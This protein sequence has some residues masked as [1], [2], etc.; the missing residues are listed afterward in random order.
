MSDIV[1]TG[2]SGGVGRAL[3]NL[4][5]NEN[6][7][8]YALLRNKD[9]LQNLN[10][11]KLTCIEYDARDCK[12]LDKAF[13]KI[14]NIDVLVNN[15]AIFQSKG[16]LEYKADEIDEIIDTNLKGSIFSTINAL[17]VMKKGRII[18]ISSVSGL[19]GI[20]N[21]TIYSS[22]KHGL[23][24]FSESLAQEIID[25]GIL[26]TDICPGGINTPLW[27]KDNPY[28]GD[29]SELILPEDIAKCVEF[30]CKLPENF[31]MKTITAF[32]KCEWH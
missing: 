15:A 29:T 25:R 26:I 24:G 13:S 32:P 23:M 16:I 17:K 21:Q 14:D 19:H 3:V 7:N 2:A 11:K 12:S 28:N 9:S 8:V 30:V 6:W 1:I 4:F 31:V 10:H 22:T 18:N 27:N 5:L 20:P